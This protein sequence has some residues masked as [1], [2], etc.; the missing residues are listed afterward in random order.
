MEG[1]RFSPQHYNHGGRWCWRG[2]PG[3]CTLRKK[4]KLLGNH[5]GKQWYG[6]GSGKYWKN[7]LDRSERRMHKKYGEGFHGLSAKDAIIKYYSNHE[8]NYKFYSSVRT[9]VNWRND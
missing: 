7:Q 2:G 5:H 4:W 9:T 3:S 8:I 6:Q 1:W